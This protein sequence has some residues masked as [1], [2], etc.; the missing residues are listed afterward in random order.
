MNFGDAIKSGFSNYANFLDRAC[1][2]EYW[3]W[4]LFTVVCSIVAYILDVG[5][6]LPV[7]R[8]LFELVTF[9][10]SLAVAVR[11]LHD[12]DRSGWWIL[13][14]L[15]PL[16]GAIVLIV[17]FCTQGTDGGNRFGRNP[18]AGGTPISPRPTV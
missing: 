16:I 15:I 14:F 6:G 10:P 1:R 7:T 13:L 11:R 5:I 3:F 17:W 8:L 4:V 12:L 18:L 2:S 9:L